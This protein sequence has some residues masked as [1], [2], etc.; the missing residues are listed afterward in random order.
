MVKVRVITLKDKLDRTV[1]TLHKAGTLHSEISEDSKTL[2]YTSLEKELH[3]T[4]DPLTPIDDITIYAQIGNH[5]YLED[6]I[7]PICF[8]P[9][10]E[11]DIPDGSVNVK[12][13]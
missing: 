12:W 4:R 10:R 1:K 11:S 13:N 3:T 5:T 9:F 2:V 6:N 8:R 7:K